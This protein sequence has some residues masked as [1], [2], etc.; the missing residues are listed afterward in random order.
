MDGIKA[1][2]KNQLKFYLFPLIEA[3]GLVKHGFTTRGGGVSTGPYASL[4]TAFHVGDRAD[5]VRENRV[6]LCRALGIEPDKIVAGSQVHGDRVAVVGE[7]EQGRGAL[8]FEDSLPGVDALVT[9]VPGLPLACFYADCVPVFLLD[10][11]RRVVALAHAGWK[12]TVAR[13]GLKTVQ[14]MSAVFGTD[15]KDCL[16]GIGPSIGPCCYEIDG[17]VLEQFEG[18][19]PYW[20]DL[21]VPVG[22]GKWRLDLWQANK[23]TLA[24]AGLLNKNIEVAGL[25]TFCLNKLFFSYRSQGGTTGRM[26]SLIMLK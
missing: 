3:T 24:K 25:C 21:V 18:S 10:P 19:F 6:L 9:D 14:K 22:P 4:N 7:A 20:E 13:I 26:A 5:R 16:A 12:G 1:V 15:P 11:V 2:M 17:G 8:S 23:R